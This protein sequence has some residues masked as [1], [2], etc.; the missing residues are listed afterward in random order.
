VI[1]LAALIV[2]HFSD[3]LAQHVK[4]FFADLHQFVLLAVGI[5][6]PQIDDFHIAS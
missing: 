3:G 5:M 4:D 2:P 1:P 6:E